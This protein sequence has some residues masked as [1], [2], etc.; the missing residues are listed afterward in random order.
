[1]GRP[2]LLE[3]VRQSR[4]YGGLFDDGFEIFFERAKLSGSAPL[5]GCGV[6]ACGSARS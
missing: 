6:V 5:E 3:I 4:R 1:M 2:S